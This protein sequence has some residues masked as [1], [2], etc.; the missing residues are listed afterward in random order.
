MCC[1]IEGFPYHSG[2][3]ER[4]SGCSAGLRNPDPAPYR[5]SPFEAGAPPR[6]SRGPPLA[7]RPRSPCG[8]SVSPTPSPGELTE[9][10]DEI[11]ALARKHRQLR[12]GFLAALVMVIGVAIGALR[13]PSVW[14]LILLGMLLSSP[15]TVRA[16]RAQIRTVTDRKE[17]LLLQLKEVKQPSR[18]HAPASPGDDTD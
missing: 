17:D 18:L 2:L 1:G 5:P 14:G 10:Q 13:D 4:R 12:V 7:R 8:A 15:W 9:L 11:S 3:P 16:G 6:N